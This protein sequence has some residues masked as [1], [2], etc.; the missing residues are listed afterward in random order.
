MRVAGDAD[1][2]LPEQPRR[3][4]RGRPRLG[5][6]SFVGGGIRF[7]VVGLGLVLGSRMALPGTGEVQ[8]GAHDVGDAG[9]WVATLGWSL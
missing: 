5:P 7:L 9:C 6:I 4:G 2:Q 3:M 8:V 1:A